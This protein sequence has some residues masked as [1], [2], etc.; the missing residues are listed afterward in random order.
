MEFALLSILVL[1]VGASVVAS[2]FT[3][4]GGNPYPFTRKTSVFTQV[5]SSFLNLLERAVG[6]QYK[7]VSRVKLIDII[8]CKKGL[9][10]KAKRAA[11]AKAK[12]KQLDYVLIDKEKMTI[13]AAVDLVNNANKDGH[14]AQ[15]DWFVN[16]A[17]EAAGIPHIR[18][19]VKSGYRPSE[20]RE[21]IMF[22][23]G[24]PTAQSS[25]P[26]R[27]RVT[28][29]AVLSPSQAKAHSTALAEI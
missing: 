8:D 7:I 3:D 22:K 6:D 27:N 4:D 9:S 19:K 18:M 1:V 25:R 23:L 28:K 2:K 20:V 10:A 13:V 11:I 14:K 21:A 15:R 24:K 17:L 26:T 16:G 12:N 29:P 5:E